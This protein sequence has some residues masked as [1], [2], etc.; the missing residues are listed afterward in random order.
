MMKRLGMD[1][2]PATVSDWFK[3]VADLLR[4]LYYRIRDLVMDTDYIQADET[5]VP[6]VD[7]EKH[8]TVKGYLWQI[9]A[10]TQKLLFF[11][12]DKGSRSKDVT[13]GLFAHFRGALQTD[14]YAVYDYY[15]GK[16]G[17]LCLNCW[18]HTRR[19]FDGSMG[20]DAARSKYAIE[21]IGLLYEVERRADDENLTYDERRDLR[22][23]LA[24]PILQTF[25]VWLKNEAPKVLPKSPIGKA[26]NYAIAHYGRIVDNTQ[27]AEIGDNVELAVGCKVIGRI[28]IGNNVIVAPN[29]V[30]V[31]DVP[32]NAIVGGVPATIIKIL[33]K[34]V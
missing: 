10:V 15:E 34:S 9:C 24:V 17:V 28:I 26:I 7:D 4:P 21:Q 2:P 29:A 1:I 19:G 25:E 33:G 6:I 13:L 27:I 3:D 12:Y 8:R 11:H 31:K 23:R 20:N 14:G 16:D 22:M 32:D 5:T 18:A 30:V